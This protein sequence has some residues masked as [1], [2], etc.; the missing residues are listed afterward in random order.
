MLRNPGVALAATVMLAVAWLASETCVSFTVMPDPENVVTLAP[1]WKCVPLPVMSMLTVCPCTTAAGS[2]PAM[3]GATT[4]ASAENSLVLPCPDGSPEGLV[5]VAERTWPA[6]TPL[7]V[8]V[9]APA[10]LVV[11]V[12]RYCAPSP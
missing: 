10:A 5:A 3:D 7:M 12:S 4:V 2:Q 6:G 1:S 11:A 9:K 8:A